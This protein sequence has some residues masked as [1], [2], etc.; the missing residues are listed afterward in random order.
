MVKRVDIVIVNWNSGDQLYSCI[1]SIREHGEKLLGKCIVV[2]N[3]SQDGST[4]FLANSVDVDLVLTGRNLGFGAACNVGAARGTSPY[5]LLLNPDAHLFEGSLLRPLTFL[6][7]Q[8]NDKIGIVGVQLVGADGLVQRTCARLPSP[9]RLLAKSFGIASIFKS[10]DFHM[11]DWDHM[12]TRTVGHVMGA[13]YLVRRSLYESLGGMDERFFVYIEDV[14]F[15]YRAKRLGY[16]SVYLAD[17]QAYHK[18]G[19]VS[20]QVKALRLFYSLRSR[21]QYGFKHFSIPGALVVG[22]GAMIVEFATRSLALL[23]RGRWLELREVAEAYGMLWGWAFRAS[24]RKVRWT[25]SG[26]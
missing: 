7:A 18:G 3:G 11:K 6:D 21:I 16:S 19:G 5:I 12:Q 8:E 2:D 15:S 25:S 23:L 10:A 24:R 4:E 20:E 9:W 13:F 14:D 26:S 17:T 1:N 22:G